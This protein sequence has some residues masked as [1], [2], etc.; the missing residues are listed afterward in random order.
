MEVERQGPFPPIP[1]NQ[2]KKTKTQKD[3][4][5]DDKINRYDETTGLPINK[6]YYECGLPEILQNSIK[7]MVLS[8]ERMDAG[9]IDYRAD[10]YYSDLNADI[11]C[12]ESDGQISSEQAW[13]LREKYLRVDRSENT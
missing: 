11:G 9:E 5:M 1:S 12:A 2:N 3:K 8:W 4:I 7:A 10:V 13:Y 6:I